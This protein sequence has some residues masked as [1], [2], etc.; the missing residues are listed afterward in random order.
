MIVVIRAAESEPKALAAALR[1]TGVALERVEP[2]A[3][4]MARGVAD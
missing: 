4:L 2:E 1:N 3:L